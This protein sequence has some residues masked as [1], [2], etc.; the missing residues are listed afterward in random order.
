MV[1]EEWGEMGSY[2]GSFLAVDGQSLPGREQRRSCGFSSPG[3][4][5]AQ[6]FFNTSV[7]LHLPPA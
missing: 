7:E 6:R 5:P 4:S 2:F 1:L 3:T